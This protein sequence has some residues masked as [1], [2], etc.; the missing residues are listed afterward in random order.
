MTFKHSVAVFAAISLFIESASAATI[1]I[2]AGAGHPH[3][4]SGNFAWKDPFADSAFRIIDGRSISLTGAS[5]QEVSRTWDIPIPITATNQNWSVLAFAT[6]PLLADFSHRICSFNP[7]GTFSG[8]GQT[9]DAGSTSTVSVPTDGTAY[10]QSFL[11]RGCSPAGCS[12]PRFDHI[13]VT[14]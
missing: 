14:G 12:D 5:F 9:V 13:K 2:Q 7:S 1:M 8:C 11:F 4:G 3:Q 6:E 10:S